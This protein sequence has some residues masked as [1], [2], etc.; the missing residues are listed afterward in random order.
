MRIRT[1]FEALDVVRNRRRIDSLRNRPLSQNLGIMYPLR[2]TKNLLAPH[3]EIVRTSHTR[4]ILTQHRIEGSRTHW[5][6]VQHVKVSIVFG[7]H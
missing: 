1:I 2:S 5:I 3:E 6:S 4:V 7:L